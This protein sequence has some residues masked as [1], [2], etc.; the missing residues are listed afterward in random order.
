MADIKQ[1]P[2]GEIIKGLQII[3]LKEFLS[4]NTMITQ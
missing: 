1:I 2:I 4:I 3:S